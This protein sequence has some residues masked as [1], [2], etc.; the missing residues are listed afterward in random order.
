MQNKQQ[1]RIADIK[2]KVLSGVDKTTDP[3]RQTL[4]P[5]GLN[6]IFEDQS[7]A[8]QVSNDGATIIKN[9]QFSDPIEQA[10]LD[11]IRHSAL[12]TN[13]LAGDGTSSTTTLAAILIKEGL[14]LVENGINGRDVERSYNDFADRMVVELKKQVIPVK[15]DKDLFYIASISASGDKEIAN[16]IVKTVKV[17]G[18]DGMVFI[19]PAHSTESEIVEDSGFNIASGMLVPELRNNPRGMSAN[20]MDVPVLI[21]DKRLYYSQEAETILS[22]VLQA[23]YKE[24]VVIAKDFIG[25]APNFFV[26]NHAKG[27]VRVLLVKMPDVDK[28]GGAALED[29]ATYLGGEVVSEKSGSLVDNLKIEQFVL[30]KKAFADGTKTLISRDVEEKNKGL[31]NRIAAIRAEIKKFG[32]NTKNKALGELQKRLASLTNGI[33]TIRVGGN[34]AIEVNE[35]IFRYEDAINAVRAAMKDG[36]LVGGGKGLFNAY[37]AVKYPA[38]MPLDFFKVYRKV[39]EAIIRQVVENCGINGDV[40]MDTIAQ[41]DLPRF[42]YNAMTGRYGDLLEEGVIDPFKVVEMTIRNS[43]SVAGMIVSS[44]YLITHEVEKKDN[45]G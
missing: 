17:A 5:K 10:V 44:G 35:K 45:N 15:G 43:V 12:Q 26:A 8:I 21:T 18:L 23:G 29:L 14:K 28:D 16:N 33:V 20:Y 27:T 1:Y 40:A 34:T 25:E 31:E 30:A 13:M 41:V 19:E 9:L 22:T 36:F 32:D 38:S 2:E 4:S 42:G 39:G 24:V 6:V 3:I 11:I 37:K 7:G